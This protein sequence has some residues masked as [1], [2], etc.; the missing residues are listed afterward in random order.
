VAASETPGKPARRARV[1]N[2]A[3]CLLAA[4]LL[5]AAG[6]CA[7][8]CLAPN[9]ET[10]GEEPP[11]SIPTADSAPGP[12]HGALAVPMFKQWDQRWGDDPVGGS[13]EPLRSVGCTVS[14][15]AMAF[16]HFGM[17]TDPGRLNAWLR[18]SGG[19]N[20]R[21]WL[22]WE[23]CV[24]YSAG[25]AVIEYMGGPD[26]ARMRRALDAGRPAVVKVLLDGGVWHWV[27]VVGTQGTGF[28][29]NDPLNEEPGPV[30]L[31]RYG[32]VHALRIFSTTRPPA[33]T[34]GTSPR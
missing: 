9:R 20:E 13:G 29:V 14:C 11:E 32:R 26:E 22:K 6:L 10:P 24:E 3:L 8:L 21:G 19:Y 34:P 7:W 31:G 25:R 27:L 17:D 2:L 15:V 12:G 28:L 4:A 18:A 16:R 23:K 30:P 33:T 1:V 5:G